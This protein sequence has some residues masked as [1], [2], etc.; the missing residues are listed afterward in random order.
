M[1]ARGRFVGGGMMEGRFVGRAVRQWMF[2]DG[3]PEAKVLWWFS[4]WRPAAGE[5]PRRSCLAQ[6]RPARMAF[7]SAEFIRVCQP[8]P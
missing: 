4:R 7:F 8:G 6:A 5:T 2:C 3:A 1:P